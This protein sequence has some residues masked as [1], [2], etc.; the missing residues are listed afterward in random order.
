MP[1][2]GSAERQSPQPTPVRNHGA[3]VWTGRAAS[4]GMVREVPHLIGQ[5]RFARRPVR[6]STALARRRSRYLEWLVSRRSPP[7]GRHR[8]GGDWRGVRRRSASETDPAAGP[9]CRRL[10]LLRP[11]NACARRAR[12]TC[13]VEGAPEQPSTR[14]TPRTPAAPRPEVGLENHRCSSR[15]PP[16]LAVRGVLGPSRTIRERRLAR[17]G[18]HLAVLAWSSTAPRP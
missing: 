1:R 6:K 7:L 5:W 12:A 15:H 18:T 3:G 2:R 10:A 17:D 4:A 8:R 11:A 9:S 14:G 13:G 16:E